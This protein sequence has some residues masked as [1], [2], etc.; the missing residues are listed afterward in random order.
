MSYRYW[1]VKQPSYNASLPSCSAPRHTVCFLK[2][3]KCASSSVQNLLMRYGER[4][5]LTFALPRRGVYLGHL[6][7]LSR[8]VAVGT[9][10]FDMLVHHT[11]FQED[12]ARALLKSDPVFVTIVREPA[13]LF[14]S[15]YS[16]YDLENRLKVSLEDLRNA[17]ENS[18][19]AQQLRLILPGPK[20]TQHGLN[21]MSYGLGFDLEQA[22]NESAV[23]DFIA[24]LD[25]VFDLVMVA[26]RMNESLVLLRHLLCW[27][28]DDVIVFKLN[29]RQV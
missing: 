2:T 27:E 29:A 25:A 22:H 24:R 10:P 26:E 15:L 20:R 12:E 21:Q 28:L 13:A 8:T 18:S 3:H 16:Y 14:E 4:H 23:R 19:L 1:R 11:R 7:L 5:Q 6:A 9:P 17:T